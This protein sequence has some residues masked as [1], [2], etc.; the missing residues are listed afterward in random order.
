VPIPRG[1]FIEL[2]QRLTGEDEQAFEEVWRTLGLSVDW[3]FTYTTIGEQAR[4]TSQRSFLRLV[5]RG[6]AYHAEAPTLWDVDFVMPVSQA[7][8]EDHVVEGA[9]LRLRFPRGDG[10]PRGAAVEVETTRPELLPA[11]VAVVAHPDDPRYRG[12]FGSTVLTPLF[13]V[14][15]PVLAHPL[16]E[17]DKGTGAAMVCTFGDLT[18]VTWWREL[19]LP[20]RAVVGRDG[21][22]TPVEWGAPGWESHDPRFATEVY[23]ELAGRPVAAARRRI[24]ELLAEHGASVGE[25]RAVSH[26]VKYYEKGE[27]PLEI[28]TSHQWFIPILALREELLARGRELRW[29]PRFMHARYQAW[30]EGLGMD[31]NISRQRYFGVPFPLWYPVSDDGSVRFDKPLL[32]SEEQLPVDPVVDVPP[33]YREEQR[34]RPGGFVGDADVMDTWATSSL[35]PEIAGRFVDDPDLFAR[36]FPMDLRPQGHDIIRTWLFATVV[37]SHLEHHSLPWS[38]AAISGFIVDPDRKKMSKSRGNVVTPAEELARFGSDAVRYWAASAH[39]GVDTTYDE[40]QMTVGRRLAIKV[41][42]VSRFVLGLPAPAG[43]VGT[44][45]LL[46]LDAAVLS[47]LGR[48]VEE[49][50]A[51][52]ESYDYARALERTEAFFWRFCNDYVELVKGRAYGTAG[53]EGAASAVTAL[54][55]ALSVLLRLLAPFLA[56]ATE[57]VWSWWQEG[58]VHRAAW[59]E[60]IELDEAAG[61]GADPGVLDV[62][63]EVLGRIRRTKSEAR[64]SVRTPVTRV[65]VTDVSSRLAQL[66]HAGTEVRE[67]GAVDQLVLTDGDTFDVAVTLSEDGPKPR[68]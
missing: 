47:Q 17:P 52:F 33:G 34:G 42:N 1:N 68:S 16:A 6:Q 25:P 14:E 43:P 36:V 30:V 35:T 15:V 54:R 56:F 61:P 19:E 10:A 49:A 23:G 57:E 59:P 12:L 21:R 51:A 28:V 13:G 26:A 48:V 67:A 27:R 5:R 46:A 55:L 24:T 66:E 40:G 58:S 18:D 53:P 31:W 3:S 39:P 7:E 9:Y 62:A 63:A 11:C 8:L 20:L 2:C 22:L 37:R 65:A 41:L 29:H 38:D 60:P 32:A 50:T 45:P 4:R 44:A 64:R